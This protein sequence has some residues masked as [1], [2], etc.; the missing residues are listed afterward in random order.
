VGVLA[1]FAVLLA[2]ASAA[3][4]AP[5]SFIHAHR[6][7]PYVN[8]VPTYPEDT[9]PAFQAAA[10]GGYVVELD[11]KLTSD[12][13][14]VVIHDDSLDRTTN[15]SGKVRARTAADLAANCRADVLGVPGTL[16]TL[17][18]ANPTVPVPTLASVLT[19]LPGAKYNIEI[20]NLPTDGDF[21]A[22]S[23][24]ANRVMDV[25][26]ASGVPQANVIVQSFWP[27]NLSAVRQRWPGVQL[28]LLTQKELELIGPVGALLF[29]ARWLSPAWPTTLPTTILLA[30][31]LGQKVVPY[32]LDDPGSV[33]A[34]AAAGVDAVITNDP[35]MAAGALP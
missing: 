9:L 19:A 10:A 4:D 6:G 31:A 17:P 2:C 14:P 21:D 15:C 16:P 1:V 29:G 30:H 22:T 24:Y 23:A 13:V 33:T 27:L 8:G 18:V 3:A 34:A 35:A 11:V 12:S 28:S 25:I 7:G 5:A 32:T 20:K 26:V